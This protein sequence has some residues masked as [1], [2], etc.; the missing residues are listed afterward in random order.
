V[1]GCLAKLCAALE[2]HEATHGLLGSEASRHYGRRLA[3]VEDQLRRA[4]AGPGGASPASTGDSHGGGGGVDEA[5]SQQE[6]WPSGQLRGHRGGPPLAPLQPA[7]LSPRRSA[8]VS[9][10]VPWER[11]GG[12]SG[13]AMADSPVGSATS[14]RPPSPV[15]SEESTSVRGN[16]SE[17]SYSDDDEDEL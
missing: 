17:P 14:S 1:R 4:A 3:R 8:G 15:H 10:D 9:R 7:A 16:D 13:G 6:P 11:G 2:H 12:G 5:G